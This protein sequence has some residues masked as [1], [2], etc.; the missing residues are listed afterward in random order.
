MKERDVPPEGAMRPAEAPDRESS[1]GGDVEPAIRV[2]LRLL[3]CSTMIE[4]EVRRLLQREYGTTLPRFDALAQLYRAPDGLTMTELSRRMMVTNGNITGVVDRLVAD[5][6]VTRRSAPEDRRALIAVLTPRG[7]RTFGKMTPR[8]HSEVRR[9]F[10]QVPQ[11][12]L[13]QIYDLLGTVK[14]SL[15]AY[16]VSANMEAKER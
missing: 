7:R 14:E 8:H 13:D 15:R 2:W 1:A 9:M 11:Q 5:G 12:E 6:L 4:G 3:T 10:G 16:A